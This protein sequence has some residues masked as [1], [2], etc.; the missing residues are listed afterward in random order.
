[1]F[2]CLPGVVCALALLS[3]VQDRA[4]VGNRPAG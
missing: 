1:M 3:R 2:L 4:L